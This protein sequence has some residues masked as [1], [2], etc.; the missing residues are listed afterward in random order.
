MFYL[1]VKNFSLNILVIGLGLNDVFK[2]ILQLKGG[3]CCD[4]DVYIIEI[5]FI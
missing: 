2:E 1:V 4:Y 3:W 5:F